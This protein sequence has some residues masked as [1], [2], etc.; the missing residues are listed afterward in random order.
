MVIFDFSKSACLY[1]ARARFKRSWNVLDRALELLGIQRDA[2]GDLAALGLT[3]A[4]LPDG[5]LGLRVFSH[6]CGGGR[7]DTSS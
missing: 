2:V 5:G 6:R 1:Q 4:I 3:D 7:S